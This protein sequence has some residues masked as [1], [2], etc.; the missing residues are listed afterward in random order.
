[1]ND[2]SPSNGSSSTPQHATAREFLAVIFRRKWVILGLFVIT[3][4][5]VIALSLS[6]PVSYVSSG[7]VLYKRGEQQS[8]LDPDRRLYS[9]W[10]QELGSEL[11]L[12][13]SV[14][15]IQRAQELLDRA[16]GPGRP[17]PTA[18]LGGVDVE[19]V[20]R[21]N[22]IAIGYMSRDPEQAH[23]I[24]DALIRAYMDYRMNQLGVS[25]PH[26]FFGTEIA[27]VE[28]QLQARSQELS[29]YLTQR[30]YSNVTEETRSLMTRLTTLQQ[31][32][33]Q[34][35][36]QLA[37]AREGLRV[38]R[39]LQEQPAGD[40]P[41]PPS[42]DA[43]ALQLI[44]Q[45]VLDQE[46][47]LVQLR[48]HYRE[49]TSEVTNAVET[50]EALRRML[51]REIENRFEIQEA[52]VGTLRSRLATIDREATRLRAALDEMP[53]AESST[54][55][56]EHEITVLKERHT[57]L[58]QKNDQARVNENTIS[59]ATVILLSP[60]GPGVPSTTRDY[61]RLALA[62]AFSLVVGVGTAFFIDGLDIT[63]RTAGHAE[64]A[65]DVPVLATLPARRRRRVPTP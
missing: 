14:P 17:A 37:E 59:R 44:R 48:E 36:A 63:V 34:L 25:D 7:R 39:A 10:E 47:R 51:R 2:T 3:T 30:G 4:L 8:L 55:Q 5:T 49:E 12:I 21:S 65:V 20:G 42:T 35:Q 62:P 46:A 53:G 60:A 29:R 28:R 9:D 57:Q 24:C 31:E 26:G 58:V 52:K 13:K 23:Q 11:Q 19:V 32:S 61:V 50:L 45:K 27:E 40:A 54:Q 56:L 15:V 6:T 1:M 41:I 43:D 18:S 33:V 16:A 22:V 38:M 64:E